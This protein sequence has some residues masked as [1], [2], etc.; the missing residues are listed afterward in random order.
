MNKIIALD[1]DGTT[2]KN[3]FPMIGAPIWDVINKAIIC[4][5]CGDKVV[6]WTCRTDE[7]LDQAI[8]AAR[9]HGLKYDYIMEDPEWSSNTSRKINATIFVDDKAPGSIEYFLNEF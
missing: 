4:Q 3:N 1:F 7:Y 9:E 2:F 6:L 8:E 5:K